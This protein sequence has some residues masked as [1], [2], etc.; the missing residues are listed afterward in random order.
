MN[1][2]EE[3]VRKTLAE[4]SDGKGFKFAA[5]I[6]REDAS[7]RWDLVVSS[8]QIRDWIEKKAFL[9]AVTTRF[10]KE[11]SDKELIDMGIIE[12]LDPKE[13]FM[14][15]FNQRLGPN[16]EEDRDFYNLTIAGIPVRHAHVFGSETPLVF[17]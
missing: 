5:I 16:R 2:L 12:A 6:E 13:G 3:K 17:A 8:D 1:S 14:Q 9:E 7:G 4:V 15:E 11:L 10:S